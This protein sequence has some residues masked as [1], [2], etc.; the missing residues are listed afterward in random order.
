M[1]KQKILVVEDEEIVALEIRKK[2]ENLGYEVISKASSGPEAIEKASKERP[3]LVLM[4]IQLKGSMDG[5]EAADRIWNSNKIPIIF[6]T[7]Y[8]DKETIQRAKA[9]GSYGYILKPFEEKELYNAIEMAFHRFKLHREIEARDRWLSTILSSISDG[10]IAVD[11]EG[12]VKFINIGAERLTGWKKENVVGSPY[13]KFLRI[14]DKDRK[15]VDLDAIGNVIDK[16]V[17]IECSEEH[18]I[19]SKSGKEV[20]VECRV[21]PCCNIDGGI[22]GAVISIKDISKKR[23]QEMLIKE[24]EEKYFKLFNCIGDPIFI[25]DKKS[26]RFLDCNSAVQ[27]I[28]GYTREELLSMTPFDLHPEEDHEKVNKNIDKRNIDRPNVY[29][30]ITKHGKKIFV[31]ILTEEIVYDGRP[32][33][34]SIVRDISERKESENV[35]KEQAAV[36]DLIN[37][38]GQ[39]VSSE[40]K[41]NELLSEIVNSVRDAFDFYGVMLLMRDE[42]GKAFRLKAIAGGYKDIFPSDL[43]VLVGEGMIGHAAETGEIQLSGDVTKNPYYVRKSEEITRSELS[44]PIKIGPKEVIGVLDIQSVELDAFNQIHVVAMNTLSTQIASAIRNA[45]LY[46]KAQKEILERK[47]TEEMIRN[48]EMRFR[49]LF[50]NMSSGVAIYEAVDNGNDF[51]FKDINHAVE[52]IEKVKKKDLIGKRV[53]EVF[54]GIEQM[55]LLDVFRE[56]WRSGKPKLHPVSEY[57]DDRIWGWR[58]NYVYKIPSGE[59]VAVYDD[60]TEQRLSEI[61]LEERQKYLESV[62]Y[63]TPSGIVTLD[64]NHRITEW[65]PGAESIFGYKRQEVIGKDIDEIVSIPEKKKETAKLTEKVLEGGRIEPHESVRFRKDGTPVDVIVAGSPIVVERELKG[66]VVIYTDISE[67]KRIERNLLEKSEKIKE[68]NRLNK[69]RAEI[70]KIASDESL[71]E[72]Q[73]VQGLLDMVGPTLGVSRACYNP[74]R[75]KYIECVREWCDEG[76]KPSVGK[77]MPLSIIKYFKDTPY[78]EVTQKNALDKIPRHLHSVAKPLLDSFT[79]K[80]NIDSILIVPYYYDGV[81]QGMLTFDICS[82]NNKWDGW[83][84]SKKKLIAEM[85]QIVVQTIT[86]RRI[87]K[88][89]MES[90]EKFRSISSA[91]QDGIIMMDDQGKISYWNEAAVKIFGYE[92]DEVIGMDLHELLAK[93]EFSKDIEKGLKRFFVDGTGPAV[94]NVTELVGTRKNGEDM[95]IELS[96]SGVKIRDKWHAIGIVRDITDRKRAEAE[97]VRYAEELKAAK[98]KEEEHAANLAQL[99]ED[100]Q[101]AKNRAEEAARAKS[102]FLANMSHE[103][104][105]PMNGI[106]GMTELALDTELTPIQRE[107]LEAVMNSAE[108]LLTIINDILDFSKIEAGKLDIESISFNLR[109]TVDET[110]QSLAI[111]ASDKGLEL[112]S[113]VLPDVPDCVKGDPGR[114][115]QI[116]V[117]LVGNAIKFTE[118]GEVVLSVEKIEETEKDVTLHFSVTDTG[119]GIPKD[120]QKLIFEAFT[121]ADGSTTRKFGGTGLGLAISNQ[122]VSMMGGRMW[123][124]SPVKQR[125]TNE[126]GPGSRFH[127]TA[128]FRKDR[129]KK[130]RERT[131]PVDIRGLKVL[132][133]DDNSTNRRVLEEMLTNWHMSPV[134]VGGGEEALKEME[135]A[136]RSG[137]PFSLILLDANMPEMDGFTLAERIREDPFYKAITIMMLSSSR[138]RGDSERC[139]KLGMSNYL[140]KPIKQ[141]DLYNAIIVAI[142]QMDKKGGRKT[143]KD[144]NKRK[145]MEEEKST[146]KREV[147]ILLAEDNGINRKLAE[148]MIKKKGW[149]VVSVT[150]G[151]EA[152]EL[153]KKQSFDLILMDVQMPEMD[154]FKATSIIRELEEKKGD[155]VPIVAMTA[156]AMKGDREM[157]LG[158]GMDGYVSK[159]MKAKELY[160]VIED[161]LNGKSRGRSDSGNSAKGMQIDL[162]RALEAVDGDED[163]LSELIE[164]FLNTYPE[165]LGRLREL[166]DDG[167]VEQFERAAHSFKGSVGN[168]GAMRAYDLAY[169][170]EKIG[171]SGKLD[172][173]DSVLRELEI[174]MERVRDYLSSHIADKKLQEA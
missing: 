169:E 83:K 49:E 93:D 98:E 53:R 89:L 111:K 75:R 87:K 134:A 99:V 151:K 92:K 91:A 124:E 50:S 173:A 102:E 71:S 86:Q 74:I 119:I 148:S 128:V 66:I 37:K 36:A 115:R 61:K 126:G 118:K 47:R 42:N 27:R 135:K 110:I 129:K 171:K 101:I 144:K 164:E 113:H 26:Y 117:N 5:I 165:Q 107:Y 133:V 43:T 12:I 69:L 140:M 154:G 160:D 161:L 20:P 55:G 109:D 46:E 84:D 146:I 153:Y 122:L 114:L 88:A 174:E 19:V 159:P 166:L 103:I 108:S 80:L 17:S 95:P 44:V 155:H 24:K 106:I 72:E 8:T 32:A 105:T 116:I 96:L 63:N 97:F 162:N 45:R 73:L 100:L 147:N 81:W 65:N 141:S 137:S 40:L 4:D 48:S 70:W 9:A 39:R 125:G 123:V 112:V 11:R 64:P 41:L 6:L 60:V 132:I 16:K 38:V 76:V 62:L 156:H 149:N 77:K 25:F 152:V 15:D 56:V 130:C 28:Y 29:T 54:P 57:R 142:G 82:D 158:A 10:V 33:W 51:I 1:S 120:K 157:C 13:K 35:I 22:F 138:R 3:D 59:I 163:L 30:H 52:R 90:E 139:M 85:T 143:D 127:F 136:R 23:Q 78:Y 121:Q 79:K 145:E 104:R 7:A 31:E 150:N 131:I 167:N 34:L 172:G 94:G 21:N 67:M 2:L 14:V 58:S 18:F 68:Q 168:F 170:L